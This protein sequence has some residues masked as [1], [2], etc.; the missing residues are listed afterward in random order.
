MS[1]DGLFYKFVGRV[2]Y[3]CHDIQSMKDFNFNLIYCR[4]VICVPKKVSETIIT[5]RTK[6]YNSH[7]PLKKQTIHKALLHK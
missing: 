4:Q 2:V 1:F 3:V 7:I 5:T 6:S